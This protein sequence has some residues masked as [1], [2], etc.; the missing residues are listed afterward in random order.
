MRRKDA[1]VT[2]PIQLKTKVLPGHRIEVAAPT[3]PEGT[4]AIVWILP[5]SPV[6]KRPFEQV[7]EDYAGPY[8]FRSANEVDDFLR[9]ERDAWDG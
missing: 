2:F 6:P 4:S 8:S 5:D 1:V 3:L 7:I 9:K